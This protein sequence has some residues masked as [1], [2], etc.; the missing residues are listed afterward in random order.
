MKSLSFV[1][2][3]ELPVPLDEVALALDDAAGLDDDGVA[4][5]PRRLPGDRVALAQRRPQHAL[6]CR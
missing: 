2:V 4:R 6:E 1:Q 3:A 5:N